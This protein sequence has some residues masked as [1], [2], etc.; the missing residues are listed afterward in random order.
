MKFAEAA[1]HHS[2][3]E[4]LDAKGLRQHV[5]D[6]LNAPTVMIKKGSSRAV[7]DHIEESLSRNG[8][9]SPIAIDPA[10]GIEVNAGRDGIVL[11]VQPGNIARAYYDLMKMQSLYAQRRAVCGVLIVPSSLASR[12]LG[13]NLARFERVRQELDAVFSQQIVVPIYLVAFE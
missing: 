9:A 13:S 1:S 6:A 10:L 3:K 7:K 2:A 4:L 11:Q 8:W 12:K 5:I